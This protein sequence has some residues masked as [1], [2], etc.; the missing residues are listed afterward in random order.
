MHS[1]FEPTISV[2]AEELSDEEW[3]QYLES[4]WGS[5]KIV[6][7]LLTAPPPYLTNVNFGDHQCVHLGNLITPAH[8]RHKPKLLEF[9]GEAGHRYAVLLLDLDHT[10]S[11][12]LSWLLLNVPVDHL[13]KGVEVVEYEAPRPGQGTGQHRMV[14]LVYLQKTSLPLNLPGLPASR[15]CQRTGREGVDLSKMTRDL[16]LKGPI[17]ANYFLSEWDITVEHSCTDL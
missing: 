9:P 15:S 13:N 7:D 12:Y 5:D 4:E 3:Q 1:F 17:A 16:A 10:P 14:F 8:A 2:E 11:P 6:P